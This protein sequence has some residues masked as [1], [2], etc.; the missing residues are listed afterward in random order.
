MLIKNL[1]N[2]KLCSNIKL[3]NEF[4]RLQYIKLLNNN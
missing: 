2:I 1:N 3:N 4:F